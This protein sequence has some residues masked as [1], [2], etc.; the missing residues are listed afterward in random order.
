MN[1]N[2]KYTEINAVIV[3]KKRVTA[4]ATATCPRAIEPIAPA[5]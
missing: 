4:Y 3:L 1:E 5:V 2:D